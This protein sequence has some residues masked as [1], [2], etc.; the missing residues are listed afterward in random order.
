M[1]G[2]NVELKLAD[3][4]RNCFESRLKV[5]LIQKSLG[6]IHDT[7]F[8]IT[9]MAERE[10]AS[11][12]P[13]FEE[14]TRQLML[15][16]KVRDLIKIVLSRNDEK[17]IKFF[18]ELGEEVDLLSNVSNESFKRILP[19]LLSRDKDLG[20]LRGTIVRNSEDLRELY[21]K[22]KVNH[23]ELLSELAGDVRCPLDIFVEIV[24][25]C[26][27]KDKFSSLEY[28]VVRRLEERLRNKEIVVSWT[29][30]IKCK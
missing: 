28:G 21:E 25:S 27:E 1:E 17:D 24:N 19:M 2:K 22:C 9:R 13:L 12:V 3:V 5:W 4:K 15:R 16:S 11:K 10:L 6:Q 23:R 14:G 7:W 29:G 26:K 20:Y 30:G 8:R 18:A